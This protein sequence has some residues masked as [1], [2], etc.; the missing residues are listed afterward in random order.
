VKRQPK[1][2]PQG[3]PLNTPPEELDIA[4]LITP[5]DIALARADADANMTPR[6]KALIE[7]A[8]AEQ[9]PDAAL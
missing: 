3:P 2:I 7:A 6:G 5:D 1:Q 9:E 8:R 4:A